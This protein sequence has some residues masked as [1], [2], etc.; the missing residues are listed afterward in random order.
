MMTVWFWHD[1]WM[2]NIRDFVVRIETFNDGTLMLVYSNGAY[3]IINNV[4]SVQ[5]VR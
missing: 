4:S 1:E 2:H 3:E 5:V